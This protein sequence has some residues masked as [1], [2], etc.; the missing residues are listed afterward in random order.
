MTNTLKAWIVVIAL[1][2][3][4]SYLYN[5]QTQ[6]HTQLN[7]VIQTQAAQIEQSNREAINEGCDYW[8]KQYGVN[9]V[10]RYNHCMNTGQGYPSAVIKDCLIFVYGPDPQ[11]DY[12]DQQMTMCIA[13]HTTNW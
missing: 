7:T 9:I 4:G 2:I 12:F 5:Q 10:T 1:V 8:S 13:K 3:G 6:V 11:W